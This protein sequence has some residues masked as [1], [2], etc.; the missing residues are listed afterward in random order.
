MATTVTVM[1]VEPDVLIRM[2]ISDFLREC[3]YR[4]IEGVR[5]EDVWTVIESKVGLDVVFA[6]VQLSNEDTGFQLANKLR[7]TQPGIDVILTSGI[8]DAA[9]K[10]S[11]LCEQ[12]PLKKPYRP[13]QVADRI[14]LL[15]ERRRSAP[16]T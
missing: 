2:S 10:S 14:H 6:E 8:A 3:G 11:D 16:K 5:A 15:L 1:V 9:E 12:G 7:Q 4:V 13:Q